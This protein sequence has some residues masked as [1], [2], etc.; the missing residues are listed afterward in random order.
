MAPSVVIAQISE[1][2]EKLWQAVLESQGLEVTVKSPQEDLT[3]Y[4]KEQKL[5]GRELPHLILMD[6]GI[7][8]SDGSSLQA[9]GVCRWCTENQAPTKV[10]LNNSKQDQIL[11][12]KRRWATRLGAADL[13]PRLFS[14]NLNEIIDRVAEIGEFTVSRAALEQIFAS[15]TRAEAEDTT[16]LAPRTEVRTLREVKT[17]EI[18]RKLAALTSTINEVYAEEESKGEEQTT[19]LSLDATIQEL[20]LYDFQLEINRPGND[21]VRYL[22]EN[23]LIPGVILVQEG[24]YFGFLSRRRILE[25]LARPFGQELFLKR[26]IVKMY[27]SGALDTMILPG[28]TSVVVAAVNALRRA[29]AL[30]YEPVVVQLDPDNYRMLDLHDL[31]LAQLEIQ[32]T[33]SKMLRNQA[34]ARMVQMEKMASLGQM[35]AEV[36][37]DIR[38]PVNFIHGNVE[39]LQNYCQS[40]IKTVETIQRE[41][42]H[43]TLGQLIETENLTYVLQDLPKVVNSIKLGAEQLRNLVTGLQSYSH[44]EEVIPDIL[45]IHECIENSLTILSNRIK[46]QITIEKR[47]NEEVGEILGFQG[48]LMQVFMNIIGNA[49]DALYEKMQKV[50]KNGWQPKIIISTGL[51]HEDKNDFL[52]IKIAD[53]GEGIPPENQKRIFDSFFTTKSAGKG[54]GLGMAITHEIVVQKHKGKILLNSPYVMDGKKITGTE[55]EV[56]LPTS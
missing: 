9:V 5:S 21:A 50:G 24:K 6:M 54:T 12:L 15:T 41:I 16:V 30:I 37:H 52:S 42:N 22:E 39:Y 45:D 7:T 34:K 49:V 36:S 20:T 23:T 32:E 44:M 53:N 47:F 29:E 38:N 43:P 14:E 27:D 28:N 51:K 2:Q 33:A 1:D 10:I 4:L 13:L 3:Q 8:T 56:L 11:P 18:V 17:D 40:L 19:G 25:M 31:L 55:F 26:P 48:Q 46:D 35:L